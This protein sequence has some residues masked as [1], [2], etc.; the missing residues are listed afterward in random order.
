MC[1]RLYNF[2]PGPAVLPGEV[3]QR[4]QEDLKHGPA[5][6]PLLELGHR[7]PEFC[8]IALQ[9]E[10]D[11]RHLMDVPHDYSILFLAGGATAQYAMVPM[12][13]CA[14][15]ELMD[16]VNTGHWS[17]RAIEQA[18]AYGSVNVI[19]SVMQRDGCLCLEDSAKWQHSPSTAYCHFVD[20]ETLTGFAMPENY[21]DAD[22]PLVS[23][24]TSSFLTRMIDWQ[25]FGVVYAG[26]QKNA[27][28]AGITIVIV[29]ND[30][31]GQVHS[32]L[33]AWENYATQ[34]AA[35]SRYN[36]PPIFAWY[37]CG[38]VLAWTVQQGGVEE[39]A[40]RCHKRAALVYECIDNSSIYINSVAPPFRSKCNVHFRIKPPDLEK[41]FIEESVTQG[42]VGLRGHRAVGG[43]RASL[44]NAMPI[45]A[46]ET[47]I[48]FMREFERT[49]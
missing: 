38:L 33:P 28:I 34:A 30:L 41:K 32:S 40:R 20:N 48:G 23:D 13:L 27:G 12:N 16:Y 29:R 4:I 7:T 49:A 3:H 22:S 42:L 17:R 35:G 5:S 36:T 25:K 24:I 19:A 15:I 1:A 9:A 11:L 26:A 37:V 39:M 14:G 21:F 2:H 44:Y 43:I 31:L 6:V 47:L 46:A 10:D 45:K 8:R 18:R